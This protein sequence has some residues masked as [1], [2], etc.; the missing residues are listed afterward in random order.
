MR[1]DFDAIQALPHHQGAPK[2]GID[3]VTLVR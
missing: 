3:G 2:G 1:L